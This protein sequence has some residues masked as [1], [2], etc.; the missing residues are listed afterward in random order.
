MTLIQPTPAFTVDV[1]TGSGT[2]IEGNDFV[3]HSET[4]SFVG[5]MGETQ[6]VSVL[7]TSDADLEFNETVLLQFE[8][9]SDA[10]V[11]LPRD[12]TGMIL[13]DDTSSNIWFNERRLVIRGTENAD[14]VDV[15]LNGDFIDVVLND[16]GGS[17]DPADVAKL[18]I[19][20][21]AANDIITITDV[22]VP[23]TIRA[24]NGDDTVRSGPGHDWIYGGSGNDTLSGGD[25]RDVIYGEDGADSI[26]G[27]EGNDVLRGG[28]GADTLRGNAGNDLVYGNG[29]NDW[30][31]GHEGDDTIRGEGGNDTIRGGSGHDQLGGGGGHDKINGGGG[32]DSLSG[33]NGADH[34]SGGSGEDYINAG[35]GPDTLSGGSE[36]DTLLGRE[37][38]DVLLGEG[39]DD[40]LI[41]LTGR[42]I[43]YGGDGRDTLEGRASEDIL[44]AGVITP[45]DGSTTQ[46]LL[47]GGIRNVWFTGRDYDTRVAN[48]TGRSVVTDNRLNSD[49]LIGSGRS[50]QNVA[51]DSVPD[52]LLSG[53]GSLLD[54]FFARID[55]DL[56]DRTNAEFIENL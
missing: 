22:A 29:G 49:F 9:I 25:S 20:T 55:N 32:L 46:E 37:G 7:V 5:T 12:A 33:H 34:L 45:P 26:L 19:S 48:I 16:G 10:S 6:Q 50:N 38:N 56:L 47:S 36:D 44:I 2:A 8:N 52:E 23:S 14:T 54:L 1:V 18:D 13:N 28:N 3:A 31:E 30:I 4:L 21:G 27:N 53:S 39:G 24:G 11:G 17:F 51:D 35:Q 42:D 15:A 40:F 41:G 43:L